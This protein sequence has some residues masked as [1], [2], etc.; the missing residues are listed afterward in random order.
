MGAGFSILDCL[1]VGM[2]GEGA[3]GT[4]TVMRSPTVRAYAEQAGFGGFEV[5]PIDND[6]Y[7]FYRLT[8]QRLASRSSA[9]LGLVSSADS[10]GRPTRAA[11]SCR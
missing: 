3:A 4:G 8:P 9:H 10:P 7:R 1:P 11:A 6:F 5:L 2:A